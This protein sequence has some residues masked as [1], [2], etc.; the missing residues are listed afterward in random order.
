MEKCSLNVTSGMTLYTINNS[1]NYRIEDLEKKGYFIHHSK[2]KGSDY[3]EFYM[4]TPSNQS[5]F[6]FGGMYDPKTGYLYASINKNKKSIISCD[7]VILFSNYSNKKI[8]LKYLN[9]LFIQYKLSGNS[10]ILEKN[11]SSTDVSLIYKHFNKNTIIPDS[12]SPFK[13]LVSIPCSVVSIATYIWY[14]TQD[15]VDNTINSNNKNYKA[16]LSNVNSYPVD[17]IDSKST[18]FNLNGIVLYKLSSKKC[19]DRNDIF[20]YHNED[21]SYVLTENIED[22]YDTKETLVYSTDI[23]AT[24]RRNG[25][26]KYVTKENIPDLKKCDLKNV[27]YTYTEYSYR[28]K[29]FDDGNL[30]YNL[31]SD[32]VSEIIYMNKTFRKIN[33]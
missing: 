14:V 26:A 3:L 21:T 22:L 11:I 23:I 25:F 19:I 15:D 5:F 24:L 29:N 8:E 18:D 6:I 1:D 17:I 9:D 20:Y 7:L 30:P 2:I 10:S 27:G 12:M 31:I 16:I 13:Y 4:D 33:K 32:L 28:E